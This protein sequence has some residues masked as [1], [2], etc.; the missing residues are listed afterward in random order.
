MRKK[1]YISY[2]HKNK[3]TKKYME[4]LV[5]KLDKYEEIEVIFDKYHLRPGHE[6]NKFRENSIGIETQL[7]SSKVYSSVTQAKVIPV[8]IDRMSNVPIYLKSR[9]CVLQVDSKINC[10]KN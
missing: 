7:I 4:K 8:I 3:I 5:Y 6:K 9:L 10:R 1:V 2:S